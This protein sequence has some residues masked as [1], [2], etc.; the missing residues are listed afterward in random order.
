MKNI[1]L[2]GSVLCLFFISCQSN[3][4]TTAQ[5]EHSEREKIL[6]TK[7]ILEQL[8][9]IMPGVYTNTNQYEDDQENFYHVIMKLYPIWKDRDDAKWFYI[10]QAQFDVQD[11][12]Y[13]Q[14]VYK[15]YRG[16]K[17]TLISKVYNLPDPKQFI[18]SKGE[19]DFWKKFTPAVLEERVGCTVFLTKKK[20]GLYTGGTKKNTCHSK[21][22]GA[23]FAES[24]VTIGLDKFTSLDRGYD[25]VGKQVWGSEKGAYRFEPYNLPLKE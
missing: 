18:G 6:A 12:P 15:V 13:R 10:E 14:R 1:V 17:D 2:G 23:S 3:K 11:K 25:D 16:E 7:N 21:M 20:N 5:S 22:A 19:R 24:E 4:I 9:L 8:S